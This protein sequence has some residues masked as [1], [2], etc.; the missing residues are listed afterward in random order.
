[1]LPAGL[2]AGYALPL[3]LFGVGMRLFSQLGLW[4]VKGLGQDPAIQLSKT[5]TFN[6]ENGDGIVTAEE[7][8]KRTQRDGRQGAGRRIP[9]GVRVLRDLAYA[10]VDGQSLKLDLYLPDESPADG[11]MR[12]LAGDWLPHHGNFVPGGGNSIGYEDLKVIEA[13]EFCRAVAEGRPFAPGFG[14]ALAVAERAVADVGVLLGQVC[15]RLSSE[16][17]P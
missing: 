10:E 9:D 15:C 12:V 11:F 7:F 14:D 8:Q 5:A 17:S 2:L 6:D 13:L 3:F 1:M 4:M 16:E